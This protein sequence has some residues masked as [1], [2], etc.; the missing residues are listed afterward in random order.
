MTVYKRYKD[1][2]IIK[3]QLIIQSTEKRDFNLVYKDI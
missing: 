3:E 2:I 1:A